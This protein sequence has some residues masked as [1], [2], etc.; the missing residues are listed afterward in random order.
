MWEKISQNM[1]KVKQ[2]I[3]YLLT[4]CVVSAEKYSDR[5]SVRRAEVRLLFSIDQ[6]IG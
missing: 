1:G 3:S 6:T 5:S 4:D 2:N